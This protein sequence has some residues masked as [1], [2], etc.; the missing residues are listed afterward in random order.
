MDSKENAGCRL[1]CAN[2]VGFG[3]DLASAEAHSY[4]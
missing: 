4:G 1:G 3:P 2:S